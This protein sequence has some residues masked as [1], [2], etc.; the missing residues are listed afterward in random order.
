[1]A[2]TDA[3]RGQVGAHEKDGSLRKARSGSQEI[4]QFETIH[5]RQLVIEQAEMG[6]E[7]ASE[8]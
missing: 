2:L 5:A 6:K 7:R 4:D 3:R 8:L 1:M